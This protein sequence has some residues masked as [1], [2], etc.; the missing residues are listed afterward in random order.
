MN[1]LVAKLIQFVN[2]LM[3]PHDNLV[4]DR[5]SWTTH[6]LAYQSELHVQVL[7]SSVKEDSNS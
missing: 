6:S 7:V 5:S 4:M 2:W 3:K 1:C